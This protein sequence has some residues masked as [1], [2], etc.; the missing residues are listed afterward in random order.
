MREHC[1]ITKAAEKDAF[2]SFS[3]I[4]VLEFACCGSKH[5]NLQ[6]YLQIDSV[7]TKEGSI[8]VKSWGVWG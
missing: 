4:G 5:H 3:A 1:L 2:I 6:T 8:P 7:A